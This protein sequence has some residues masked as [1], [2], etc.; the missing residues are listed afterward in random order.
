MDA[1]PILNSSLKDSTVYD[2]EVFAAICRQ[3][4]SVLLVAQQTMLRCV[5]LDVFPWRV[6]DRLRG[7]R[8]A[9]EFDQSQGE[10][11]ACQAR[12][13]AGEGLD[14]S[15]ETGEPVDDFERFEEAVPV[16]VIELSSP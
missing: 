3:I 15:G 11:Q 16:P 8:V 1:H 12:L 10:G 14:S 2:G 4:H 9:F 7:A 5:V 13:A 6:D